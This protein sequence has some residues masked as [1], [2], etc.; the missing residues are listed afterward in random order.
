MGETGPTLVKVVDEDC[1]LTLIA[2][3]PLVLSLEIKGWLGC[4]DLMAF[5]YAR[6]TPDPVPSHFFLIGR[7]DKESVSSFCLYECR[8]LE[9]ANFSLVNSFSGSHEEELGVLGLLV[10]ST[11]NIDVGDEV[12]TLLAVG[13]DCF[14]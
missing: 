5:P 6:R 14:P 10:L 11:A 1:L 4:P 3:P 7:G 2:I 12:T 13:L 8:Q 9:E